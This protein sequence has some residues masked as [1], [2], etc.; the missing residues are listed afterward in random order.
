M[1]RT[2]IKIRLGDT[3][4]ARLIKAAKR[5]G[6]SLNQE[7]TNRVQDSFAVPSLL[8][9]IDIAE[10]FVTHLDMSV[11]A[12]A[13]KPPKERTRGLPKGKHPHAVGG[14]G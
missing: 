12:V 2:V 4:R 6:I 5:N 3:F 7:I 1:K 10:A 9:V 11:E 13:L 8:R 14:H